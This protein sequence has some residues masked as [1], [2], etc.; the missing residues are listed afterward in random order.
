[1]Y[2]RGE[3]VRERGERGEG[4]CE[5]GWREKWGVSVEDREG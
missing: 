2:E 3:F 1:M 5:R 4:V